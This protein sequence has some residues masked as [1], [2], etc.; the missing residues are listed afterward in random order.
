MSDELKAIV[1]DMILEMLYKT[2]AYACPECGIV[3]Q[4]YTECPLQM[5][6]N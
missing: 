3:T 2:D 4:C 6:G 5:K 1:D